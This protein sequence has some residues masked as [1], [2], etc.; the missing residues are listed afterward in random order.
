[1]GRI[2]SAGDIGP[3]PTLVGPNRRVCLSRAATV[4]AQGLGAPH[5]VGA[6]LKATRGPPAST[7]EVRWAVSRP[8]YRLEDPPTPPPPPFVTNAGSA[9]L[10]EFLDVCEQLR[11]VFNVLGQSFA[12]FKMAVGDFISKIDTT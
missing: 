10:Q 9:G 12:F 3:Q 5:S 11:D 6:G 1:M 7:G 8:N 2:G 4:T